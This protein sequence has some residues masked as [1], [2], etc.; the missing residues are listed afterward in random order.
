MRDAYR[1][2]ERLTGQRG[3]NF[4][5]GFRHLPPVKRRA[6]YAAYAFCRFADDLSDEAVRTPAACLRRW[7]EELDRCYH[8]TPTHPITVAL[9]DTLA[10]FPIP[11]RVFDD[12]IRGCEVDLRR[13]RYATFG[14]LLGYC[15]LVATP[16]GRL[17]LA[18]FGYRPTPHARR[19]A[20]EFAVAL[21]LTNILRDVG[22]DLDR[23]RIY[24]PQDDLRRF[25]CTEA[26]LTARRATPAFRALMAFECR[27]AHRYFRGADRLI[28]QF[29]KD[30]Q[31]GATLMRDVYRTVL[32]KV[33]A[34]PEATL[35][36]RLVVTARERQRLVRAARHARNGHAR[37]ASGTITTR[38]DA[39]VYAD[40][41]H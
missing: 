30:A 18:V 34:A 4:A 31:L 13:S 17:C 29:T 23:G 32:Q 38:E 2:C 3:T 19:W 28:P 33:E 20:R 15:D 27:R 25:G 12:M 7:R 10:R 14:E 1:Y 22:D 41:E 40:A 9:Q 6:I 5:L 36:R 26:T 16:I 37:P 39:V 21:Q 35:H 24:L 11:R 8:G